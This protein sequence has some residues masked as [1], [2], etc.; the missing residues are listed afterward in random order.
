MLLEGV[1]IDLLLI[2]G[3]S[4][5]GDNKK[6]AQVELLSDEQLLAIISGVCVC[7]WVCVCVCVCMCV[8]VCVCV[9]G[10]VDWRV[11]GRV[12]GFSM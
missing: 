8:C 4:R 2:V 9:C 5:I 11:G 10:W 3:V 12:G 1:F 6:V 7:V